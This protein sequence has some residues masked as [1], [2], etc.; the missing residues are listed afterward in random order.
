MYFP[1]AGI[2]IFALVPPIAAF[3]ISFFTSMAGVSGAFLLLPFQVSVLGFVSPAVSSTNLLYNVVGTPGGVLRYFKER[4][5]VWPL[6]ASI[7]SGT[8]PGV[9][10]G[11]YLRVRLLPDPR[12]FKFFVGI[13]L[14]FVGLRLLKDLATTPKRPD[15]FGAGLFHTCDVTAGFNRIGFTFLGK[16]YQFSRLAV[17][18]PALGVGIVGG[19]YGIGG[20]AIIAPF[21]VTFIHLPIYA[22]AGAVLAAN[23]LTSFAGVVFYSTI[24]LHQGAVVPPD[25]FLGILFGLGGMLGMYCGAKWQ[26]HIP[27]RDIKLILVAIVFAVS[28]KY[29]WQ[30]FTHL[31]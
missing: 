8:L 29:I 14:L 9:L 24:P 25:W 3:F 11:Y 26:R 30:Y 12:T 10:I 15:H 28:A 2:E 13:V 22:I 27:E 19:M 20:G 4:R 23:F 31:L 17:F 21:L 16:R 6:V 7:I 1:V 5:M 18:F